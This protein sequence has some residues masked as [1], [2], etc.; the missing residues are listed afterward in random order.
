MAYGDNQFG[1]RK[2]G[3]RSEE[4]II[5]AVSQ[6]TY[7]TNF[8]AT[9]GTKELR[10]IGAKHGVVVDVFISNRLSKA[11]KRFG[12][13]KF[14]RVKDLDKLVNLLKE[15]WI[16]NFHLF[17][18]KPRFSR[19]QFAG[20]KQTPANASKPIVGNS[21]GSNGLERSFSNVV[22]GGHKDQN[23]APR[24]IE[25]KVVMLNS[26]SPILETWYVGG[27]WMLIEFPT[28][29]ARNRFLNHTGMLNWLNKILPWS[30]NFFPRERLIWLD[31]EGIPLIAWS[32]ESTKKVAGFWGEVV[33][34][35]EE[36]EDN[37]YCTRVCI[38]SQTSEIIM[39]KLE[40]DV[41]GRK[42]GVRVKEVTG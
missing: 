11:G 12:F 30:R 39:E 23:S 34:L 17:A 42:Y 31:I 19:D 37:F 3:L 18:S 25:G 27:L 7:V 13:L 5:Q 20:G 41:E 38:E 26:S 40:V 4:D 1:F 2:R 32:S 35:D 22:M 24:K 21:K 29:S 6:A 16:G 8:P 28:T 14:I 10:E 33:Y 15:E 9:C 36:E